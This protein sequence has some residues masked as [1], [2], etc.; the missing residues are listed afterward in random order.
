[1]E[2]VFNYSTTAEIDARLYKDVIANEEKIAKICFIVYLLLLFIFRGWIGYWLKFG[3]AIPSKYDNT[4]INTELE[5]IQNNYTK[6]EQE[7]KTFIYKSLIN[8]KK[9]SLI[10]QAHYKLSGLTVA[11]NYTFLFKESFFDSTAL[12]DLGS[13]WG[14]LGDK[15][16]YDKYFKSYS[17]KTEITGSRVLWTEFKSRE[18]PVSIQ[19]ATSHWAHSHIIPANRNIMAAMIKIKQWDIVQIEG[20]LVDIAYV[21]PSGKKLLYKTSMSRTDTGSQGDRGNGSCETIYVT[22][23]K[24]GNT[25]YK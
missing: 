17:A 13:T 18:T 25:I 8:N 1:M 10:P 21:T 7:N 15:E 24:I 5:P 20:E 4:P 16:F 23:V 3:I 2:Q 14:K 19:Y 12:Y 6:E 22:S 9:V 11:Y